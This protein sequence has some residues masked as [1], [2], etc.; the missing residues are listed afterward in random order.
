ME[1]TPTPPPTVVHDGLPAPSLLVAALRPRAG[2]RGDATIP[3]LSVG[4]RNVRRDVGPYLRAC[5]LPAGPAL[6]PTWPHVLAA[7]L[8]LSLLADPRFPLPVLGIVH[9]AQRIVVHRP[10]PVEA[11]L[12]LRAHVAGHRVVRA[13]ATFDIHTDVHVDGALAW[14]GVTTV[15]SRAVRGSG[16]R[17][18]PP[19]PDFRAARSTVVNVREDTGRRYGAIAHDPNPIH[20]YAWTARLFGFPQAIAHGMWM[21]ARTLAEL[22]R[23]VPERCTL[24]VRF[25]KPVLLP[26]RVVVA[27]GPLRAGDGVGFSVTDAKG[28]ACIAGTV[29]G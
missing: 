26:S 1:L 19:L 20:L 9:A 15:L 28:Q 2:L 27:G 7:P 18:G 24:D 21:V 6:P 23:D 29:R 10:L 14:Q 4:A 22:D 5:G 3:A 12:E 17:E 13:G 25:L 11:P 8:H 16:P